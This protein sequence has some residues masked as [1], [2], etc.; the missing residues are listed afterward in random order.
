MRTVIDEVRSAA[1][2]VRSAAVQVRSAAVG[3]SQRQ[4][5]YASGS[6]GSVSG[7]ETLG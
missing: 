1:V 2:Q 6:G 5:R 7:S 4:R 3:I